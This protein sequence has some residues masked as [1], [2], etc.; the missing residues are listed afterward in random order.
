LLTPFEDSSIGCVAGEIHTVDDGTPFGIYLTKKGHLAQ[1]GPLAHPFL[2]YAQSGNAAYRRIVFD[3]IGLFDEALWAGHDADLSWRMQLET[4]YKLVPAS[5][6][7]VSH[8]QDISYRSFLRQKRRHAHGAVLLYKKYKQHRY[9]EVSSFK[10]TYWE[11][12]SILKRGFSCLTQVCVSEL[13]S[14]SS[15]HRDQWYQLVIEIGEKAG[16]L[17]GSIRNLTWYP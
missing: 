14:N 17:E 4:T 2:P 15:S 9:R 7:A 10:E 13:A 12:R 16:R 1:V 3:R 8:R 11:Y 6:A 5:L